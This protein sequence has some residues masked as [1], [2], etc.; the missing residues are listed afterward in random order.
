MIETRLIGSLTEIYIGGGNSWLTESYPTNFHTFCR[1][2]VLTAKDSPDNYKEV[3]D[4]EKTKLEAA[5]AAWQQPDPMFV[6]MW[7]L[8]CGEFGTYNADNGYFELNGLTDIT[9]EQAKKI[10]WYCE[11][12]TITPELTAALANTPIRTNL[13]FVNQSKNEHGYYIPNFVHN[14]NVEVLNLK[15]YSGERKSLNV[16]GHIQWAFQAT[17]LHTV[18]GVISFINAPAM[19]YNSMNANLETINITNMKKDY[20]MRQAKKLSAESVR[21]MIENAANTGPITLTYHADVFAKLMGDTSNEAAG[22][23]SEQELAEWTAIPPI[24]ADKNITLATI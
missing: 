23:L 6:E 12:L 18:M 2:K 5:D 7:N 21:Y 3:T 4:A 22:A 11:G 9:Y 17:S 1:R 16:M 20:D 8:K 10:V 14:S 15:S 19:Y 24:A 13:P